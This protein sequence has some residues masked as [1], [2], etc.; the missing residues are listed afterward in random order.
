MSDAKTLYNRDFVLWSKTQANGLRSVA[1]GGSNQLRELKSQIRRII[2]HL[3]K[4]ENSAAIG[5]RS[6]WIELIDAPEM[7][8][9]PCSK[10]ALA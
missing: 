5:P 9:R 7:K 1:R 4:L 8:S 3:L 10:I 2:E 6:G